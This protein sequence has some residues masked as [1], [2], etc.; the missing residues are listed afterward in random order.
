MRA[1]RRAADAALLE[2]QKNNRAHGALLRG[3]ERN[4]STQT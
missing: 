2:Y 3:E 4:E 1:M